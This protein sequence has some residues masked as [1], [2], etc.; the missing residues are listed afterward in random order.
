MAN[1]AQPAGGAPMRSA[2]LSSFAL[3]TL[4]RTLNEDVDR[5]AFIQHLWPVN[6]H[7]TPYDNAVLNN[8]EWNTFFSY[9]NSQ[10]AYAQYLVTRTHQQVIDMATLLK[11]GSSKQQIEQYLEALFTRP[12]WTAEDKREMKE[13][14]IAF[15]IRI[16]LM[17]RVGS[18]GPPSISSAKTYEWNNNGSLKALFST[19]FPRIPSVQPLKPFPENFNLLNLTRL[20][21]IQVEWTSNLADH[22]TYSKT[23]HPRLMIFHHAT[24]LKYVNSHWTQNSTPRYVGIASS[25]FLYIICAH[26]F[27]IA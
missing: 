12:T 19:E 23:Y 7:L 3:S 13:S 24:F 20:C 2:T 17:I 1:P 6:T 8:L 5:Q 10:R 16:L 11:N 14:S 15:A 18:V 27:V 4:S 26:T 9:Y 22:L 25:H 21:N